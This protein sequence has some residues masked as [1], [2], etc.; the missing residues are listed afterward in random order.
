V[1]EARSYRIRGRVQ[2]VGYRYFA[3]QIA[4]GLGVRGWV[5]NLPNGDVEAHAEAESNVLDRFRAELERGPSFSRVS[6][7]IEEGASADARVTSFD[8][9]G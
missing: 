8:I 4:L 6:E 2:G 3:R 1:V 7:V 9:R 5:R